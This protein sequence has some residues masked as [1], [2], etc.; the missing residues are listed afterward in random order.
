MSVFTFILKSSPERTISVTKEEFKEYVCSEE[1]IEV[2]GSMDDETLRRIIAVHALIRA[3]K[4]EHDFEHACLIFHD[5]E[6]MQWVLNG[7]KEEAD[8]TRAKRSQQLPGA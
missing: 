7:C 4:I 8:L 1:F 5:D 6:T 3:G 2:L